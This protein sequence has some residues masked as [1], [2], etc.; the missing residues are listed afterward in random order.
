MTFPPNLVIQDV[1]SVC[2]EEINDVIKDS[3][4]VTECCG[5]YFH[6]TC[7][8][9][10]MN[11]NPVCPLCRSG[12]QQ[13]QPQHIVYMEN[14]E[15]IEN[16]TSSD[17]PHAHK[18]CDTITKSLFLIGLIIATLSIFGVFIWALLTTMLSKSTTNSTNSTNATNTTNYTNYTMHVFNTN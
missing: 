1:C 15:R 10:W 14:V 5:K 13:P 12:N 9:Q 6:I 11:V 17:M 16:D 3:L 4:K 2:L 7:Y 8:D 18:I